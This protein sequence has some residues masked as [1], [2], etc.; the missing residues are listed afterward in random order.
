MCDYPGC[1]GIAENREYVGTKH[2]KRVDSLPEM[3]NEGAKGP[4]AD[5]VSWNF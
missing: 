3:N 1:M 4:S 2:A 5:S